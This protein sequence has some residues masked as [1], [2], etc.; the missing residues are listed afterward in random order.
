ML[1][2]VGGAYDAANGEWISP[3]SIGTPPQQLD[4]I[5]DSGSWDL[6]VACNAMDV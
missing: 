5:L 3:V 6:Y 1:G 4:L 2:S